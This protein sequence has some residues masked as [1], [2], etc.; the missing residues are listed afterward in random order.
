MNSLIAILVA[1][2]TLGLPAPK[3]AYVQIAYVDTPSS[4][5]CTK[6]VGVWA[7]GPDSP[8]VVCDAGKRIVVVQ[9]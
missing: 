8:A 9:S 1:I 4:L 5:G 6:I 2:N 3:I 7:D